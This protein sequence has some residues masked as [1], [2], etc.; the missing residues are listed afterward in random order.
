M[1]SK[2][3]LLKYALIV[4]FLGI[5]MVFAA[6][7]I[8]YMKPEKRIIRHYQRSILYLQEKKPAKAIVE[9]KNALSIQPKATE[10]RFLLAKAYADTEGFESAIDEAEKV[11]QENP[12]FKEAYLFLINIYLQDKKYQQSLA[13]CDAFLKKYPNNLEAINQRGLVLWKMGYRKQAENEFQ[14]IIKETPNDSKAYIN[15][16]RL[17]WDMNQ[18]TDA[19]LLLLNYLQDQDKQNFPIRLEFECAAARITGSHCRVRSGGP[20]C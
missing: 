1:L 9:L 16:S 12:E 14:K 2:K 5:V 7:G 13:T 15:L 11:L 19:I 20:A 4:F 17:Y 6:L 3:K 10:I 8:N 18:H